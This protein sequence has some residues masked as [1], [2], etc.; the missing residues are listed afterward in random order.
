MTSHTQAHHQIRKPYLVMRP[1]D[2]I[3]SPYLTVDPERIVVTVV[4]SK[5][6]NIRANKLADEKSC[7]IAHDL[8]AFLKKEVKADR[9]PSNLL[10]L[11]SGLGNV[12]NAIIG[13]LAVSRFWSCNSLP[14]LNEFKQE[15]RDGFQNLTVW[16]EVLQ[17][18]FLD[19]FDSGSLDFATNSALFTPSGSK[20][21]YGNWDHYKSNIALRSQQVTNSPKIVRRLGIIAMDTPVEVDLYSHTSSRCVMGSRVMVGLG[22]SNDYLRNGKYGIMHTPGVRPTITNPESTSCIVPMCTDVDS[23]E[24]DLDVVV[25]EQVIWG[26]S[27]CTI[28]C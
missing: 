1:K 14:Q 7:A 6:D 11:Q 3:G 23:T 19:L 8:I 26:L 9:L 22:G 5:P 10:P 12:T 20:R 28:G 27:K 18:T 16:T 4:S 21:L 24:H 25:T 2:R 17:N 15:D 13:G